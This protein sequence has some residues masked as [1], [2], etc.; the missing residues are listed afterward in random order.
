MVRVEK[1]SSFPSLLTP[2]SVSE[3][4]DLAG[5]GQNAKK[6]SWRAAP[7]RNEVWSNFDMGSSDRYS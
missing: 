3:T 2:L 1:F 7:W 5:R 6:I 4:I